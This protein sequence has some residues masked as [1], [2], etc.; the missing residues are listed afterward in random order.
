MQ[1]PLH[2]LLPSAQPQR[3]ELHCVPV[4]HSVAS[5]QPSCAMQPPRHS[6]CPAAQPPTVPEPAKPLPAPAPTV[7]EPALLVTPPPFEPP[8]AVFV[9][10]AEPAPPA[11]AF[12]PAPPPMLTLP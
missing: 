10:G 1:V 7:A 11:D 4:G 3:F 2:S 6:R 9:L 12:R 8:R 5:Q